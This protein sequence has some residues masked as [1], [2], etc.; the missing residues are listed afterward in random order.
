[1]LKSK[2]VTALL[3]VIAAVGAATVEL[4]AIAQGH[5]LALHPYAVQWFCSHVS[6]NQYCVKPIIGL[7][8]LAETA[9]AFVLLLALR[10]FGTSKLARTLFAFALGTTGRLKTAVFS[11]TFFRVGL[12]AVLL[13]SLENG[14][15]YDV[16]SFCNTSGTPGLNMLMLCMALVPLVT[17]IVDAY[18]GLG[19]LM[20]GMYI[21]LCSVLVVSVQGYIIVDAL[22]QLPNYAKTIGEAL[23]LPWWLVSEMFLWGFISVGS[24]WAIFRRRR[25][26]LTSSDII[27]TDIDQ[28]TDEHDDNDDDD[29]DD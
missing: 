22:S 28:L 11:W 1:M 8:I 6:E 16:I 7:V 15:S 12:P 27:Q 26:G 2:P 9:V 21:A 10:A 24:Y 19:S 20:T 14:S 18:K 29:S 25:S 17:L 13:L 4:G 3:L 23:R 5:G